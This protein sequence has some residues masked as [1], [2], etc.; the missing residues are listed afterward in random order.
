MKLHGVENEAITEFYGLTHINEHEAYPENN[1]FSINS[2]LGC[3]LEIPLSGQSTPLRLRFSSIPTNNANNNHHDELF[4]YCSPPGIAI[5]APLAGY[6]S[7][8]IFVLQLPTLQFIKNFHLSP[9]PLPVITF[10]F[11]PVNNQD[12]RAELARL[13]LT[14]HRCKFVLCSDFLICPTT[15]LSPGGAPHQHCVNRICVR[16]WEKTPLHIPGLQ[17]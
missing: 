5:W 15:L 1:S 8:D 17:M 9:S 2:M 4:Q 6:E 16:F 3:V 13:G 11:P 14:R 10:T 7:S 12:N